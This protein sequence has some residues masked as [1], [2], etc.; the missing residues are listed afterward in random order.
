M[1]DIVSWLGEPDQYPD[2][3]VT[4]LYRRIYRKSEITN[5][6]ISTRRHM[7]HRLKTCPEELRLSTMTDARKIIIMINPDESTWNS[8]NINKAK[9]FLLSCINEQLK[10]DNILQYG[11]GEQTNKNYKRYGILPCYKFCMDNGVKLE[12]NITIDALYNITRMLLYDKMTLISH[13]MSLPS[14]DIIN[15]IMSYGIDRCKYVIRESRL[16]TMSKFVNEILHKDMEREYYISWASLRLDINLYDYDMPYIAI[17]LFPQYNRYEP[18]HAMIS[19]LDTF[20]PRLPI[21]CY[22]TSTLRHLALL[23]GLEGPSSTDKRLY[24]DFLINQRNT[25]TFYKGKHPRVMNDTSPIYFN[26]ICDI[27]EEHLISYGTYDNM[28]CIPLIELDENLVHT[29][30]LVDMDG[31]PLTTTCINKLLRI[32]HTYN[33][34]DDIVIHLKNTIANIKNR[35]SKLDEDDK[36]F[37]AYYKNHNNKDVIRSF[38]LQCMQC[39][40]YMRG[41]DGLT[42]HSYPLDGQTSLRE[43]QIFSNVSVA[44]A[45]IKEFEEKEPQI[46]DKIMT[47]N[48]YAIDHNFT[49]NQDITWKRDKTGVLK[50]KFSIIS[51][52]NPDNVEAC[53]RTNSNW[54]LGTI[55]HYSDLIGITYGFDI[56]KVRFIF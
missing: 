12:H 52:N 40:M 48:L 10:R 21:D 37:I 5:V 43:A 9:D 38:L 22:K 2:I 15:T 27:K 53:I 4:S 19:L 50:S 47:L 13:L 35:I 3:L 36:L 49:F 16:V 26:D 31:R 32:L 23:E 56:K 51:D 7:I 18:Q 46:Y 25:P 6:D 17:T 24:Y 8:D 45:Q 29:M 34:N 1:S 44:L 54:I 33:S 28:M 20:E 55:L 14:S 11:I 30:D 41:W 39:S 42:P